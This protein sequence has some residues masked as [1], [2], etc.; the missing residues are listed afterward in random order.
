MTRKKVE[1]EEAF[2]T[3][4]NNSEQG[5][6]PKKPRMIKT[7]PHQKKQSGKR[8]WKTSLLA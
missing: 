8:R 3:N 5:I 6:G 1:S 4:E 2:A 7:T